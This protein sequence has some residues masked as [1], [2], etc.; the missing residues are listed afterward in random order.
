[1]VGDGAAREF[2]EPMARAVRRRKKRRQARDLDRDVAR[3]QDVPKRSE[4]TQVAGETC[5]GRLHASVRV[6]QRDR[7]DLTA[8]L[9]RGR[10]Q[11]GVKRQQRKSIGSGS[12]SEDH[13]GVAGLQTI[14]DPLIHRGHRVP[15]AAF[16]VERA[17]QRDQQSD[18][19][20]PSDFGFRYEAR[21]QRA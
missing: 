18:H 21:R 6:A 12:L 20:P 5:G 17:H 3:D 4:K 13:H 7:P 15:P 14:A 11:V 10:D 9:E 19:R 2:R 16:D 8:D 1:M